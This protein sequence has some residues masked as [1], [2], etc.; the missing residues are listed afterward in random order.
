VDTHDRRFRQRFEESVR[1]REQA[2]DQAFKH[3]GV[4]LLSL[5]TADDLVRSIVRFAKRKR[6]I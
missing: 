2:I 5:S 3:A 6:K 4:D 1:Q